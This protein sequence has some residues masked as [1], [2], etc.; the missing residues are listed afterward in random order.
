MRY[1]RHYIPHAIWLSCREVGAPYTFVSSLESLPGTLKIL[2][3][4]SFSGTTNWLQLLPLL[5]LLEAPVSL[6]LSFGPSSFPGGSCTSSMARVRR[7]S[8]F[9]MQIHVEYKIASRFWE[10]EPGI[11]TLMVSWVPSEFPEAETDL[12]LKWEEFGAIHLRILP[13]HT[14][15]PYPTRS[16]VC[17]AALNINVPHMMR[18]PPEFFP[19][20]LWIQGESSSKLCCHV[21]E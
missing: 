3:L 11:G 14:G 5:T 15:L 13:P 4:G 18:T 10:A 20:L 19:E 2:F 8:D 12:F 17:R 16:F 1:L 6:T 9:W 21:E 7:S